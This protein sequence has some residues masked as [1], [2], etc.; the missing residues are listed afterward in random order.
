MSQITQETIISYW[1]KNTARYDQFNM[2]RRYRPY[3]TIEWELMRCVSELL[4]EYA[5][6]SNEDAREE[7]DYFYSRFNYALN[8][9]FHLIPEAEIEVDQVREL[10]FQEAKLRFDQA[11]FD[12]H[13]QLIDRVLDFILLPRE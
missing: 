13:N 1:H 7:K 10:I 5:E 12:I 9:I 8:F 11:E 6:N 4:Y 2:N 3:G